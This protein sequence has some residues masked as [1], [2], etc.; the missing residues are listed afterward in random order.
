MKRLCLLPI[1]LLLAVLF[2]SC[3]ET[4]T[5]ECRPVQLKCEHMDGPIGLDTPT[6]RLTW[7]IDD[8]RPGA[9]QTAYEIVVGKDPASLVEGGDMW[10]SGKVM[11]SAM[12]VKYAGKAL[13][14]FTTYYW[15]VRAWDKDGAKGPFSTIASFETG[16]MGY[17]NWHG[18][19]ITDTRDINLKPAPY[20]RHEFDL[21]KE[22]ESARAYI[23]V[24][25]LYEL[26][27]NG[28]RVGDHILDP[29][30]THFDRRTLY[31]TYD[32]TDMLAKEN[33]IG[34]ILGNGWYNHQ[35]TAVWYFHEA[36]WRARPKLCLDLRITYTDGSEEIIS[37]DRNWKT[38]TGP[39]VFNSIYTGE[40]YDA[41]LE[42]DGWDEPGF[43]DSEWKDSTVISTPSTNIVAQVLQPIRHVEEV[44]PVSVRKASGKKYVFDLGRNISGVSQLSVTGKKGTV[45]HV[46]HTEM[47]DKKGDV[48]ISEIIVHYRPTDDSDPFQEDIYTLKGEGVETF[49]PRFNYKGFRYVEVT[50]SRPVE[51]D[52]DSLTAYFMHSDV[53]PVG[54]VESSSET[55]NKI[56][57][58]TNNAYLSNL[59][60]YPTDCP[61]REKN[62]WTGDAHIAVETGLYNFDSITVYEKWLADHQDAQLPNG[63]LPAIIPTSDWGFHWAN[64]PDWTSTIA[65]IPWN[66]YLFYG[67]STLLETCY[68]NIKRYVDCLAEASPDYICNWGLGD[69]VPVKS[70]TP[71]EFTS[72]LYFY[73]DATI[74]AKTAKLLGKEDD[75][76]TYSEMAG[77]I[78]DAVNAKYFDSAKG[79]YGSGFQTELSAALH[80][81]VVP[82]ESRQLVADKLAERVTADNCHLDVGLLGTK[83][84]LNALSD[85]GYADLAWKVASQEDY[86]SWGWWIVNGATTLYENWKI[87]VTSLNH[88]MFGEIGAWYY[89]GLGG[90]FPDESAP[91]FANVILR[92]NFVEGLDH[93]ECSHEGPAGEIVSSWKKSGGSV[94]YAVTIP[95]NSTATLY[96][97]GSE[98]LESG[99]ALSENPYVTEQGG[100]DSHV[101]RLAAGKYVFTIKE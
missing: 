28:K 33:A 35:S 10:N 51:L 6:P 43:D 82:E 98:V 55:L 16:M 89:K 9:A 21:S 50:S 1:V 54:H 8:K 75:Y 46:K 97:N 23:A 4:T 81:G 92:P 25:G 66:V 48:D 70:V 80:W 90:I 99:K 47:I 95:P 57:W 44:K 77:R 88:I 17:F 60:A 31:V 96:L 26:S 59:F 15:A 12:L 67:D 84:I 3:G 58:A 49:M 24:G 45:I 74:L 79:I 18:T 11:D 42:M 83:T 38:S 73:V 86:P 78:K 91:G 100:A 19:W 7:C 34:V 39:I 27:I 5:E 40:H 13:E 85:N 53:P 64:G 36:P 87:D 52:K 68:D 2:V 72:S 22:V 69:W 61:Q 14:P 20:F 101:L 65:I 56:W 30:Y 93:F 76:R 41:R 37:T 63:I 29:S 94:E 32:V 62:G 71:M